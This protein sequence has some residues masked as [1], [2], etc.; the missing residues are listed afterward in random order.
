MMK[1]LTIYLISALLLLAGTGSWAQQSA[2]QSQQGGDPLGDALFPP[3]LVMQHQQAIGLRDDQKKLIIAE[4]KKAQS[5]FPEL[6]W[7]LHSE[8]Q[9]LA[10]LVKPSRADEQ[11]VLAQLDK[12]LNLE[13]EIKR[14]HLTLTLRIKN[15]LSPEQQAK[16]LAIMSQR[17]GKQ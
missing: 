16:L 10:A 14:I 17:R 9:T 7:Q 12:V 13:R 5:R 2:P 11:R 3:E 4:I 1:R 15:I 6:E 8:M